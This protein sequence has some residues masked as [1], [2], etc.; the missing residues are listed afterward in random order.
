M[1][2]A[3]NQGN[4]WSAYQFESHQNRYIGNCSGETSIIGLVGFAIPFQIILEGAGQT[5][6]SA[7]WSDRFGNTLPASLNI[8][9]LDTDDN[10]TILTYLGGGLLG[11]G[12]GIWTLELQV[13]ANTYYFEEIKLVESVDC[14]RKIAFTSDCVIGS[15]YY[16]NGF[17]Q[18]WYFK[19]YHD[20]PRTEIEEEAALNGHNELT[21]KT[22]NVKQYCRIQIPSIID[23]QLNALNTI[24]NHSTVIYYPDT[25]GISHFIKE[26]DIVFTAQEDGCYSQGELTFLD[27]NFNA[28]GCCDT[29]F[30]INN[31]QN[32]SL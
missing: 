2:T 21:V 22:R 11:V 12:A 1:I 6:T 19:G 23:A 17:N 7:V 3:I 26:V 18:C 32:I 10:K 16:G 25:S 29:D 9:T 28:D 4:I 24:R 5:P 14:Y 30:S 13:G 8:E 31:T 20:Q 15:V 27:D